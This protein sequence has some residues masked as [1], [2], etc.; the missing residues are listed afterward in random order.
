MV[1]I[2]IIAHAKIGNSFV[3][4]L[5]DML[6]RK[7]ENLSVIEVKK[8]QSG[9]EVFA[10]TKA[11]IDKL[12]VKH[13]VLILTDIFGATPSNIAKLF[14]NNDKVALIHG[15]NLPMLMRAISY[16]NKD[17]HECVTKALDGAKNGIICID[18]NIHK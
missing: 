14:V 1:H 11:I 5:E 9:C 17:L 16:A 6:A 2:I 13:E 18:N 4:C 10:K 12:I 15:L 7:I 8:E 3:S